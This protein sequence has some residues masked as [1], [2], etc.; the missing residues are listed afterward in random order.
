MPLCVKKADMQWQVSLILFV[1]T[2]KHVK[3]VSVKIG[4][5]VT[6]PAPGGIRVRVMAWAG[7]VGYTVFGTFADLV[8]VWAGMGMDTG[9]V[10]GNRK[11]V[12]VNKP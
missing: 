1:V 9:A 8:S 11:I 3:S 5:K 2:G 6:V 7:T 10:P 4:V 12:R